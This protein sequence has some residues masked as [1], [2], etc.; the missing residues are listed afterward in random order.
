MATIYKEIPVDA[1]AEHVWA[2]L[3]DVGA[4]HSRLAQ[5]FVVATQLEDGGSR[6]VT[7][8]NGA[9]V[10][11]RIVTIDDERRRLAYAVVEWETTHHHASFQV[12]A[13]GDTRTRIVWIAD[14][15]PDGLKDLVD[16]LMEGGSAAIRQTLESTAGR[17]QSAEGS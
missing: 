10:R 3:R 4:I 11:E 7:F 17:R 9:T 15:L 1:P 16:G 12:F 2:A 14:I 6:L 13:D 5:G 8:A